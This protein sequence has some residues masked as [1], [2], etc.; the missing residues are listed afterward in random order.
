MVIAV[1]STFGILADL[2]A[3]QPLRAEQQDHEADHRRKDRPADEE[4]G[5]AHS[6]CLL[7]VGEFGRIDL[8][9]VDAVVDLDRR[10]GLKLVLPRRDHLLAGR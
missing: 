6:V 9:H 8:G 2:K 10:A 1:S 5:E 4:L 7:P 3:D